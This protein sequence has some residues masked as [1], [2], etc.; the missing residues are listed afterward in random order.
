[1]VDEGRERY[2]GEA[3]RQIARKTKRLS[4]LLG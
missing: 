1:M 2:L 4:L 3:P